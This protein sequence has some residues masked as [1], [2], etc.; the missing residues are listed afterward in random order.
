MSRA[1]P[2]V[3]MT[4]LEHVHEL[5]RR[6]MW[7]AL[8]FIV[9]G[10]LGYLFH[11]AI[12][13]FL[14]RPLHQ[15]LYY[16]TPAGNFNFIMK[17]CAIFGITVAIPLLIYNL[18]S[19]LEP[20]INKMLKRRSI[21]TVALMSLVLGVA[22]AVFAYYVVVPMSLQFFF[23]F[24]IKGISPLIS[25][26]DYLNFILTCIMSFILMFQ[27]PLLILFINHIK[28]LQPKKLLKYERHVIVGSLVI[29]L[30]LPF[31][32]DPLTQFLIAAPIIILFNL[33]VALVWLV[34]RKQLK[35]ER[36][37]AQSARRVAPVVQPVINTDKPKPTLAL[38]QPSF[39]P[40]FSM[41]A[42]SFRAEP[43]S[44]VTGSLVRRPLFDVAG[45]AL[46]R[47]N[48]LDLTPNGRTDLNRVQ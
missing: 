15:T 7:P 16:T 46:P 23:G 17:V 24:K 35:I 4:F 19:F 38:P 3:Q 44:R 5:R 26:D 11:V 45:P 18:V 14:Q 20:A 48:F 22:G 40:D 47:R 37:L 13:E 36:K 1:T 39:R 6:L 31:T 9:A 42:G 25:A 8:A 2:D 12:I 28:P 33:S 27:L 21:T 30:V 10:T 34:N 29:A 32:Y 41:V 43:K